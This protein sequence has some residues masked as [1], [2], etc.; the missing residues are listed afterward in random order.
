M[1]TYGAGG[2]TIQA[3]L[4]KPESR[5]SIPDCVGIFHWL[6][7]SGCSMALESTQPITEMSARNTTLAA[8]A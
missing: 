5:E 3:L 1:N 2:G 6:N 7:I 8:G 4:Y